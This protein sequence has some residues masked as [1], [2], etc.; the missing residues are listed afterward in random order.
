MISLE[1]SHSTIVACYLRKRW[2]FPKPNHVLFSVNIPGKARQ[3]L[4]ISAG[5]VAK[6]S[7]VLRFF[8]FTGMETLSIDLILSH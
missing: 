1:H 4:F 6:I 2:C 3:S 8:H 7:V 5:F